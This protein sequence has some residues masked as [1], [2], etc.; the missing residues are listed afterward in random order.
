MSPLVFELA[1][2]DPDAPGTAR[3]GDPLRLE[4]VAA[5]RSFLLHRVQ[6]RGDAPE[7]RQVGPESGQ[8]RVMPVSLRPAP[9][10]RLRQQALAPQ[11]DQA[12]AV[13]ISWVEGPDSHARI[14]ETSAPCRAP[15]IV[16][17][18][19]SARLEELDR[20]PVGI[21]HLD[22]SAAGADFHLIAETHPDLLQR[23]DLSR[24][25]GH[26]QDHPIPSTRLLRLPAR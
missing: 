24:E 15:W 7:R 5:P 21:L 8:L 2:R 20:I 10:H 9:K 26:A 1:A 14:R 6:V 4:L 3:T 22:L 18:T 25:I 17:R 16:Q 19:S 13:Q 23:L 11:R 12:A